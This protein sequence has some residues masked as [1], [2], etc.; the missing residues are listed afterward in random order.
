MP[1]TLVPELKTS[2]SR[3]ALADALRGI[4]DSW[5][6]HEVNQA[7]LLGI[8]NVSR[9]KRGEPLPDDPLVLERAGHLSAIY[10][11]LKKRYPYQPKRREQWINLEED[12][13]N[14]KTPLEYMLAEGLEGI[15]HV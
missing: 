4:L 6:V 3:K 10:R 2:E 15:K 8:P 7:A 5:H 13:F 11:V 12:R 9:L 1:R 14:G